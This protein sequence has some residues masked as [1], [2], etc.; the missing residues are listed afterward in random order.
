[1]NALMNIEAKKK[2]EFLESISAIMDAQLRYFKLVRSPIYWNCFCL[3]R[4]LAIKVLSDFS[5]L[6]MTRVLNS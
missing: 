1:M 5:I 4:V 3:R 2:F 6:Y